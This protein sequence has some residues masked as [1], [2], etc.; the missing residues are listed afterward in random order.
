MA[1]SA[2]RGIRTT[3][4]DFS[5]QGDN[6][7][8]PQD[9]T[10]EE[11]DNNW[12]DNAA[13]TLPR[14]PAAARRARRAATSAPSMSDLVATVQRLEE[15]LQRVR[16]HAARLERENIQRRVQAEEDED[17]EDQDV[18][19]TG[20]ASASR[21]LKPKKPP[22]FDP[23]HKDSNVRTWLFA[24]NNYYEASG[25]SLGDGAT[26]ITYAVTLLEG[27]ALEWWRQMALL[28]KAPT[29]EGGGNVG[30][31]TPV[32][33]QMLFQ[34]P[35]AA[36]T[37]KRMQYL[38]QRPATWKQ[39]EDAITSRFDL[40]NV[41]KVARNKIKRLRQTRGVQEY[42][43]QF[44]ALCAE[45]DDMSEAE[46]RDKY[47][48]GLKPEIQEVLAMHGIEDFATM[49][50]QAERV[51]AVKYEQ[52]LKQRRGKQSHDEMNRLEWDKSQKDKDK[53]KLTCYNCGKAGH[54][55]RDCRSPKKTAGEKE[56]GN[57]PRQ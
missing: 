55:A 20:V 51:D 33:R 17:A 43:R 41:S 40:I 8:Q 2:T 25:V 54:F 39:F 31:V 6:R 14:A 32:N 56:Q 24:L 28:A 16:A 29:T 23:S 53:K 11:D 30:N 50:A 4:F 26:R 21:H 15:E 36:D 35:V 7:G 49:A 57:G 42:T 3:L 47:F 19:D 27:P 44:L 12:Q 18:E 1:Q 45:I 22:S 38:Q 37:V 13:R 52:Y 10:S 5:E 9:V 48:D 34:T 46:R